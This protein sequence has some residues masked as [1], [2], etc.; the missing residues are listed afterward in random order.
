MEYLVSRLLCAFLSGLIISQTGSFIQ[1]ATRNILA[2]PSTLGFDGLA[3][4][5]LLIYHSVAIAFN[6]GPTTLGLLLLGCPFFV[7]VGLV[8]NSFFKAHLKFEKLILLGMTFNLLVGAIFSL[9]QFFFMAF[10]LPFP[11]ELWFGHFRF[12]SLE[13]V[14]YLALAEGFILLGLYWKWGHLSIFSLGMGVARNFN[15]R[16]K[17]LFGFLFITISVGTFVVVSLSG[18]FAFLGLIFPL[19]AR[20]LWFKKWDLKGELI[21]GAVANGMFLMAIDL[22][23]Y[24]VPILGAEIPVG[25]I[26]TC[27]GAVSLILL[28]W[29]SDSRESL[30]KYRD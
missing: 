17:E 9:W 18:A 27:V 28:L 20:K 15:L 1:L 5:W 22:V 25:L 12:S 10:N 3:I 14:F 2:G 26:V 23:C 24:H 8:F 16:Q 11:V 21:L 29:S 4:L 6:T 30:A 13:N 19:F 7:M